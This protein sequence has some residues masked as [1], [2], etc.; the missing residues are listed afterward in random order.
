[1]NKVAR[2][3]LNVFTS[4]LPEP[5]DPNMPE[6]SHPKGQ[7]KSKRCIHCNK[8]LLSRS[9]SAYSNLLSYT[10]PNVHGIS[11]CGGKITCIDCETDT[12]YCV[13]GVAMGNHCSYCPQDEE[14]IGS[15]AQL[16]RQ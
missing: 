8:Q 12:Q 9:P 14:R 11:R 6:H 16:R 7:Y 13:H 3:I 15:I 10:V 2:K 1:M 5:K 4:P